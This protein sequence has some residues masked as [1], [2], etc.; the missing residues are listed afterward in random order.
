MAKGGTDRFPQGE[1]ARERLWIKR[2]QQQWAGRQYLL[3]VTGR[4][5]ANQTVRQ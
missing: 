4:D 1:V 3:E 2:R 5:F